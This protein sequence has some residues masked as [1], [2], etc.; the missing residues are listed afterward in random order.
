MHISLVFIFPAMQKQT[1]SE[2]LLASCVKNIHAR[3]ITNEPPFF[4]V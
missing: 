3:I 1:L 4:K 2:V